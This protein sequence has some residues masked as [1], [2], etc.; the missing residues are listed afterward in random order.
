MWLIQAVL[1][2]LISRANCQPRF[3]TDGL[4]SSISPERLTQLRDTFEK[5]FRTWLKR[6]EQQVQQT[7]GQDQLP[8]L[9]QTLMTLRLFTQSDGNIRPPADASGVPSKIDLSMVAPYISQKIEKIEKLSPALWNLDRIDQRS[10][11]LDQA[12]RYGSSQ[13]SG[14]GKGVTIYSL[15]S[16]V[17]ASHQEFKS[18]DG[19]ESRA[20]FGYD[21]VLDIDR[22]ASDCNGHGTHVASTAIGRSVG[23][24]K[25]ASLISVRI[26]D[27]EGSGTISDTI[28]GI[29]WIV[30]HRMSQSQ[31]GPAVVLMSLGVPSGRASDSLAKA[32]MQ[33]AMNITVVVASGNNAAD[34]CNTVPA[35][36]D[37]VIVVA[38]SNLPSK[39]NGPSALSA[40]SLDP[41]NNSPLDSIYSFSNTGSCVSIFGPGVDILGACG[42]KARCDDV[43]DEAY[44]WSSG[45]SMAAPLVAG[46]AAL[47]LETNPQFSPS[48]VKEVIIKE[49]TKGAIKDSRILK[50]T[51][52]RL[53]FSRF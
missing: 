14:T 4:H 18:W 52:N 53:V 44:A 33:L 43:N 11:A 51:P 27:C 50:G 38:A 5:P 7:D 25:E 45:T 19:S 17:R 34:A 3:F 20:T 47:V 35:N 21:F 24:A 41:S 12:Y 16:G 37:D 28:K 29:D 6:Q 36:L 9:Q 40:F 1:I 49:A 13:S 8:S 48:Q 26:L 22:S 10:P 39:W 2:V 15:D 32:V 23:V 30:R 31:P 42:G 46:L